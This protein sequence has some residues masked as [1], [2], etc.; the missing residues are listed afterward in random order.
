MDWQNL[1]HK[2]LQVLLGVIAAFLVVGIFSGI[3]IGITRLVKW[4]WLNQ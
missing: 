3:I 1:Q 2:T 4:A